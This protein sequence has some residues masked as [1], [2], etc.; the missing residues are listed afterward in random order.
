M[1]HDLEEII[2]RKSERRNKETKIDLP[3]TY[4]Y[5]DIIWTNMALLILGALSGRIP[6]VPSG[7]ALLSPR[8]RA[9]CSPVLHRNCL[10]SGLGK[11]LG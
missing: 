10:S 5:L 11:S 1:L 3:V 4:M 2:A 9:K 6:C 8:D 7:S